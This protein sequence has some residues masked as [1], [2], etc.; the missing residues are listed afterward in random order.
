MIL[1]QYR[2]ISGEYIFVGRG[3]LENNAVG[4]LRIRLQTVPSGRTATLFGHV[5]GGQIATYFYRERDWLY[6]AFFSR[7]ADALAEMSAEYR[8]ALWGMRAAGLFL[9]CASLLLVFSQ[10]SRLR[11]GI[12]VL[13]GLGKGLI[14]VFTFVPAALLALLALVVAVTAYLFQNPLVLLILLLLSRALIIVGR[15][16]WQRTQEV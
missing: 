5:E 4:D 11:G 8:F 9:H 6:R 12:P 7:R 3:T 10:I 1:D 2:A 16:F 13:G 15:P 14:A